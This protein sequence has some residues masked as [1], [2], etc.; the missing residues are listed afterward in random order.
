M[1][2]ELAELDTGVRALS[3]LVRLL[4]RMT[5]ADMTHQLTYKHTSATQ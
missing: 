5:V 3:A 1:S 2:L 4:E